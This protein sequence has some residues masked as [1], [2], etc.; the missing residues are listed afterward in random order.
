MYVIHKRL[1]N[2]RK[3]E[4]IMQC[5]TVKFPPFSYGS[6]FFILIDYHVFITQK[7]AKKHI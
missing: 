2:K 3:L 4:K 6:G 5:P 7:V 1:L